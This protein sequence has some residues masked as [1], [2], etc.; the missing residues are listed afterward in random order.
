[1]RWLSK[2]PFGTLIVFSFVLLFL[3]AACSGPQGAQGQQGGAGGTGATGAPGSQGSGG[4]SGSDGAAGAAGSTGPT[5][6]TGLNGMPGPRGT[7]GTDGETLPVSIIIVPAGEDTAEQPVNIDVS[8]NPRPELTIIGAG[9]NGGEIISVNI[10]TA[11]GESIMQFSGG[12]HFTQTGGAFSS[13][14]RTNSDLAVG[15]YTIEV[16]A[17][18]SGVKASAPLVMVTK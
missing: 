4:S 13:N 10:I 6:P 5:G 3:T 7:T 1:V 18:P 9:F 17:S 8:V 12:G 2:R 14:W 16:T 11:T 15:V